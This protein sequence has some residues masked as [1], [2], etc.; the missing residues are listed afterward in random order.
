MTEVTYYLSLALPLGIAMTVGHLATPEGRGGLVSREARRLALPVAA[1]VTAAAILRWFTSVSTGPARVQFAGFVLIVAGLVLMRRSASRRLAAGVAAVAVIVAVLPEVPLRWPTADTMARDVLTAVHILA[2]LSW[3]GGLVS[4]AAVGLVWRQ[5][6]GD[7]RRDADAAAT[8]WARTWERF[9]VVAL[10][11]VAALI[12]TGVWQAWVHVGTPGQLL[13]T[14]YGRYLAIKLVLVMALLAAGGYNTRVVLPE[15]RARQRSGDTRGV[16]RLAAQHF[17]LVVSAEAAL[18]VGV[19]IVVPFLHGSARSQ[20]GWPS[21][22]PFDLSV[23]GTGAVL[24]ALIVAAMWAG[25]RRPLRRS[26]PSTLAP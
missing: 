19:L 11:A 23:F 20:A 2:A 22:G 1:F 21:A 13:T 8:D 26:E 5:H 17:P 15:I 25:S 9:S 6:R 14:P 18:G 7:D 10:V 24:L 16:L 12:V 4:L 3:V